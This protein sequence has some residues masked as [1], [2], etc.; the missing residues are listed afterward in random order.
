MF[1][2]PVSSR[3]LFGCRVFAIERLVQVMIDWREHFEQGTYAATGSEGEKRMKNVLSIV[4]LE[5]NRNDAELLDHILRSEGFEFSFRQCDSESSFS[6]ALSDSC[7][8]L[9]IS[10]FS[11]PSYNG[12]KALALAREMHPTTPFI[13]FSGTIGEESAI[14][15]LKEGA[16]D[17]VLKQRPQRLISAIRRALVEQEERRRMK[18]AEEQ[19][20]AQAQVIDLATDAIIIRDLDDTIEFINHGAERLYGYQRAELLGRRSTEFMPPQLLKHFR[21]VKEATIRDG[22]WEGEME[23][24]TKKQKP[25]LVTSRWT[26]VRQ[27]NRDR[28]LAINSDITEK[29]QL[30]RQFLRAQRLESIGTL[31]SGIAHDLNNILAPI[32]MA[33]ELLRSSD[34]SPADTAML[35]IIDQSARRGAEIVKQVL[36][37]VR[38]SEG[39]RTILSVAPLITEIAKIA[40]ETFPRN[41]QTSYCFDPNL[42]LVKADAGQLHQVL[43][44]LAVNARDAMP[45]GGTLKLSA[46]NVMKAEGLRQVAIEVEDSGTGI[47]PE[48]LDKMFDPF[49][50][51]KE[52]SKGTGLG[53]ST[54]LGIIKSHKG[55]IDVQSTVG[56]GTCFRI[57]LPAEEAP[58]TAEEE[59]DEDVPRGSGELILLVDDEPDLRQVTA[60]TLMQHGYTVITAENGS[61]GILR[62]TEQMEEIRLIITDMMMPGVDGA[63]FAKTVQ[64]MKPSVLI[65]ATTGH[66]EHYEVPVAKVLLRKPC[67]VDEFLRAVYETLRS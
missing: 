21:E 1:H 27:S 4:L 5:D 65:I 24:F 13:F 10:D 33:T 67:P 38:G 14:D 31:A 3:H 52:I 44:N 20:L 41:I 35:N 39:Q 22:H 53:L 17:Y 47:P 45:T 15:A 12:R 59:R 36:T 57:F 30:E 7:P 62:F 40:R 11:L 2:S 43:M 51:T 58:K 19:I 64:A 9:I 42:S 23:H 8:D 25:V 26:L 37:F 50:T 32:C 6:E 49:F 34:P 48:V 28:I 18:E 56:K 16:T 60:Q 66:S 61:E 54:V 29:K 46:R 55:T 63:S